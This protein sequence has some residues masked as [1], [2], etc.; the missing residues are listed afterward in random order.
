MS[1]VLMGKTMLIK[2]LILF[3]VDGWSCVPSLYLPA[4]KLWWDV[5]GAVV[6]A[7]WVQEGLEELSHVEGLEGRW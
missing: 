2:S 7:A 3:S 5:Q 6:A 4:A 1:L